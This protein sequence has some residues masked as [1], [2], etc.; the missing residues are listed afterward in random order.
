MSILGAVLLLVLIFVFA[1]ISK[2][3]FRKLIEEKQL[4]TEQEMKE[5]V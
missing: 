5:Q 1:K 3:S 2:D 4:E